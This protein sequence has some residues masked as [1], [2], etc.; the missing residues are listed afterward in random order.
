MLQVQ[1]D[2]CAW[3]YHY[4]CSDTRTP[5]GKL[6]SEVYLCKVCTELPMDEDNDRTSRRT[7]SENKL[8]AMLVDLARQTSIPDVN[9]NCDDD[10]KFVLVKRT[11]RH[12]V[13]RGCGPIREKLIPPFD[14]L[15][16]RRESYSFFDKR[17]QTQKQTI[18]HRLYHVN[19]ECIRA[20][21]QTVSPESLLV[22][23]EVKTAL[24][25]EHKTLLRKCGLDL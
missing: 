2:G 16:R 18:G 12:K 14:Y 17:S 23:D 8:T 5:L 9:N 24:T 11:G 3:W 7:S 13:C 1:C 4:E 21:C 15:F 20:K 6:Q 19:I 25:H 22:P 10:N